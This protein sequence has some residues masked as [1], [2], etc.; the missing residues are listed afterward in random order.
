MRLFYYTYRVV[1]GFS[2]DHTAVVQVAVAQLR[3][4]AR[5]FKIARAVGVGPIRAVPFAGVIVTDRLNGRHVPIGGV[6]RNS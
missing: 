1:P 5:A 4:L 6:G 2:K 3:M